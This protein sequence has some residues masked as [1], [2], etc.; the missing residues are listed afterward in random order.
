L[1]LQ[2]GIVVV[3]YDILEH[4]NMLDGSFYILAIEF[5]EALSDFYEATKTNT[6]EEFAKV[7]VTKLSDVATKGDEEIR[8]KYERTLKE[9]NG[10]KDDVYENPKRFFADLISDEIKRRAEHD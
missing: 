6:S 1:S 5:I 3:N 10:L 2:G 9:H 7:I 4:K 8:E